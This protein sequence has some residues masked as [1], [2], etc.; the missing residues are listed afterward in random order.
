[1]A[2]VTELATKIPMMVYSACQWRQGSALCNSKSCVC[3]MKRRNTKQFGL[4][5]NTSL[6]SPLKLNGFNSLEIWLKLASFMFVVC[7]E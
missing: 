3:D 2:L 6:L 5:I 1:M 4:V 7:A